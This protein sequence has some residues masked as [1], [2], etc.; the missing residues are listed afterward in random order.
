[1]GRARVRKTTLIGARSAES[2][3]SSTSIAVYGSFKRRS[4]GPG[5]T[6]S[7]RVRVANERPESCSAP[8]KR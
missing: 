1:M 5:G 8:L 7:S 2:S 4:V 6:S 3:T